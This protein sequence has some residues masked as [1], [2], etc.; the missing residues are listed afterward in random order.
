MMSPMNETQIK[1][2]K[3]FVHAPNAPHKLHIF[4]KN[5]KTKLD[6]F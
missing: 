1:F 4:M 2:L 5:T 6:D 3:K